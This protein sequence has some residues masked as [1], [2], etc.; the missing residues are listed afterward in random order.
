MEVF[1]KNGQPDYGL[2]FL[3][4]SPMQRKYAAKAAHG[5][6]GEQGKIN[7]PYSIAHGHP[8][9]KC[10]QELTQTWPNFKNLLL[11]ILTE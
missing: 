3:M 4:C 9:E 6:R 2:L 5:A 8:E 10:Q 7:F 1:R 11:F